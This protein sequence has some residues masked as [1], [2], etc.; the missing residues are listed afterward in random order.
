MNKTILQVP[1][2]KTLKDEAAQAAKAMGF[3]SLQESIRVFLSRLAKRKLEISY[4]S[5]D[6]Y[7]S[8]KAAK[9]YEKM[10]RDVKSGKVKTKSFA[11]VD[12]MMD[13]LNS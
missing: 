7:L 10:V 2:D 12:E 5:V 3:S 11:S 8:P 6:E 9:R 4:E 1:I 13:Y